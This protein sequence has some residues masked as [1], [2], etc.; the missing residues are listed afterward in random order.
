MT[1]VETIYSITCFDFIF[2]GNVEVPSIIHLIVKLI[3]YCLANKNN[4]KCEC[5]LKALSAVLITIYGHN[6][7]RVIS[8]LQFCKPAIELILAF[9]SETV[10]KEVCI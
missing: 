2:T 9:E 3:P 6:P 7:Y 10:C 4:T 1:S 8:Y 5:I